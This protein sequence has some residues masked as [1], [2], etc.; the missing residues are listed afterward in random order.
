V[1]LSDATANRT[2]YG[3]TAATIGIDVGTSGVRVALVDAGGALL[4][5]RSAQL[6]RVDRRN[7]VCW[8]HAVESALA[9]LQASA[10]LSV[11][12]CIAVDGT[13]GTIVLLNEAG[14]PMHPASLYNDPAPEAAVRAVA[15]AAPAGS[16]AHGA[17]S[18]LAKLLA[19]QDVPGTA[20]LAHQADWVAAQLGAPLGIS[21]ENNALKTGYDPV[22][23]CWPHWLSDL[24]I[25]E[26]LLPEVVEPGTP[27][28]T[29]D[30]ALAIRFGLPADVV[31][32][33]GTTD[34]CAAFLATGVDTVGEAVTSLGST[35][36]V[37]QLSDTPIFSAKYG[38]YSHRLGSR[39]LA[40][41]AL[42]SGGAALARYF[43]PDALV[44]LSARIDTSVESGLDYYPLPS[45]GERFPLSDPHL[46][47][48]DTP[49]P[50]DDVRFLHGL[51]EG[52]ARIEA[53]GYRRLADLGGPAL[54]TV[55]TVGTGAR[56]AAWTAIRRRALGVDLAMARSE[57]A[58]VGAAT[59]AR[60]AMRQANGLHDR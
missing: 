14:E 13:S 38:V 45:P 52:I 24:G 25:R 27:I 2:C 21:D 39:W 22:H 10:D 29:I 30:P 46:L 32:A 6:A 26:A 4:G 56:N 9:A 44:A 33:A 20:R 57:D 54:G 59:L 8:W 31:I 60:K 48:R 17:A 53:L 11:V 12:R 23:R 37:K 40:G 28:G 50:T 3:V 58:A 47:P 7:P 34:G 55:R 51:L 36:T 35:L 41:G 19:M 15:A 16:A 43:T 5:I 18:P 49:R 42:N 1:S